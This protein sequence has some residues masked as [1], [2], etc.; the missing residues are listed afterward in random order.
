MQDSHGL[1]RYHYNAG[2][3][4]VGGGPPTPSKLLAGYETKGAFAM[5]DTW[6]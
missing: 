6:T 2:Q 3:R 1:T 5:R 4:P